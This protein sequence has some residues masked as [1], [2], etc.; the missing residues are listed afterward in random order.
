M[1]DIHVSE[2]T[3][4]SSVPKTKPPP[5]QAALPVPFSYAP[6]DDGTDENLLIL[7]HGL[8][9]KQIPFFKLGSQFHLP[10]TAI[11]AL[12]APDQIPYLDEE[13]FQWF[14]SFDLLG[15]LLAR[16]NPTPAVDL[17]FRIVE[18]LTTKC[19][20]PSQRLH[21][22]GFGQGGTVAAEFGLSWENKHERLGSI[23]SINGPLVSYPTPTTPFTTPILIAWRPKEDGL[24]SSALVAF[25]KGYSTVQE[26]KFDGPT[27]MPGKHHW[28]PIMRFWSE[29]LGKRQGEGLYEI[30]TGTSGGA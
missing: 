12:R 24:P 10:Q 2:S 26:V 6:S 29:K 28:E 5:D 18:H 8:G 30:M 14:E 25:R 22:F 13:A 15:E 3:S 11:L 7:L 20:W 27:P 23:V 4:T 16:P 9:D 17:L 1:S 19:K 21:F